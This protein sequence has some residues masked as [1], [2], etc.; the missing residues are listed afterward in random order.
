MKRV[1]L[2]TTHDNAAALHDLLHPGMPPPQRAP[3]LLHGSQ[4]HAAVDLPAE[5]V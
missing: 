1:L 5:G 4:L 3:L 2:L